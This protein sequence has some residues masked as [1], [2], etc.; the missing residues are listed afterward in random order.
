VSDQPKLR[1]ANARVPLCLLDGDFTDAGEQL[2]LLDLDIEEGRIAA[3]HAAGSAPL[4]DD[5]AVIDQRG[6]QVWPGLI[7]L[8]T[9]LDKGH[10][11][12]RAANPDGTF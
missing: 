8:H 2:T 4:P 9:H 7:D 3:I 5:A 11:W 10:I 6:G 1:I 12:P